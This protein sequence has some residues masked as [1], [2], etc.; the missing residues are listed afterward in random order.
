MKKN[1]LNFN[2]GMIVTKFLGD[3]EINKNKTAPSKE[4]LTAKIKKITG[5]GFTNDEALRALKA[6]NYN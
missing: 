2:D 5:M 4:D 1:E 3:G 6:S